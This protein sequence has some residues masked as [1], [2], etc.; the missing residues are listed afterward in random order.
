MKWQDYLE[1]ICKILFGALS[2]YVGFGLVEDYDLGVI[3][4]AI[5]WPIWIIVIYWL[6]IREIYIPRKPSSQP[7]VGSVVIEFPLQDDE[8]GSPEE[9]D[10]IHEFADRLD[11]ITREAGVGEY[12][13]DEFGAGRCKLFFFT[14]TPDEV[15]KCIE[16]KLRDSN[17]VNGM[18]ATLTEP[19][20][21]KA[22]KYIEF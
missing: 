9:R 8:F 12:D 4:Q 10:K 22:H 21:T 19:G 16:Y 20:Q 13:G 14:D 6:V 17:Y 15:L 7:A 2:I 18:T 5:F 3:G 1:I 11:S